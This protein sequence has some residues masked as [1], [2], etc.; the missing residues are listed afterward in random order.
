MKVNDFIPSSVMGGYVTSINDGVAKSFVLIVYAD[1]CAQ[2]P[3][4]TFRT[5]GLHLL[6]VAQVVLDRVIAMG[7]GNPLASFLAH[8]K[9]LSTFMNDLQIKIPHLCLLSIISVSLATLD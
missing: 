3:S 9:A 5:S 2:T 7:G 1:F 8:L 4:Q 6:E